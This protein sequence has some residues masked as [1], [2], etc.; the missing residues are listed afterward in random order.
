MLFK[1]YP[2]F[3]V[4]ITISLRPCFY[5]YNIYFQIKTTTYLIS[6]LGIFLAFF[7]RKETFDNIATDIV[8]F[9]KVEELADFG[10]TLGTEAAGHIT[11]GQAR[12]FLKIRITFS[13]LVTFI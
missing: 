3:Y 1:N 4:V 9:A 11:V 13:M 7:G 10:R 8:F 2:T 6:G 12:D 5:L